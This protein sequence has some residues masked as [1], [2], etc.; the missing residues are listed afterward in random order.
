MYIS[1]MVHTFIKASFTD[2]VSVQFT[3]FSTLLV[4]YCCH[5]HLSQEFLSRFK[6]EALYSLKNFSFSL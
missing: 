3:C 5:H 4:L 6:N 2:M 1:Y